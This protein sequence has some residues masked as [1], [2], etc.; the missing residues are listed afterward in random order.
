M[1][2]NE[3]LAIG[4]IGAAFLLYLGMSLWLG[5]AVILRAFGCRVG[6]PRPTEYELRQEVLKNNPHRRGL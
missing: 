5:C 3:Y 1:T 6:R 2:G 4:A